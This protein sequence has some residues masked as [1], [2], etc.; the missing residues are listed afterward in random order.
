MPAKRPDPEQPPEQPRP[1]P[2]TVVDPLAK[3]DAEMDEE[4][5]L[6]DVEQALFDAAESGNVPAIDMW[7]RRQRSKTD[8]E[9]VRDV[10]E[11][12]HDQIRKFLHG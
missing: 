1:H 2:E 10:R 9:T 5:Q 7:L 3:L 12:M 6:H 4:Q 8:I 11:T